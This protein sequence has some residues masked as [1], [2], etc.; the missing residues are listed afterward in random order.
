VVKKLDHHNAV[1]E[2]C[3]RHGN[4]MDF[5]RCPILLAVHVACSVSVLGVCNIVVS[6]FGEV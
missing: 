6:T 1:L 4:L 2:S 5:S 3:C